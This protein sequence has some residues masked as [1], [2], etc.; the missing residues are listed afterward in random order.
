[1]F[2]VLIACLLAGAA[3][4]PD[5]LALAG[6]AAQAYEAGDYTSAVERYRALTALLPESPGALSGLGRSLACLGRTA[7]ALEWLGRAADTRAGIDVAAVEAAFG[8]AVDDPGVRALLSRL[9]GNLTPLVASTLAFRLAEKDL[10]P[11]SVA[12]DPADGAFYV[13]SL[14]KRKIVTV[15]DG[16]ARDFVPAK[17]HGLGAVLGMK[18]DASRRELWANSCHG[19]Y[20]PALEDPDPE[21]RGE[22]AVFRFA[23]PSG[24]LLAV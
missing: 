7:E 24:S 17:A 20:P 23:L 11:E 5:P 8:S 12:H 22:A 18:V 3:G 19:D 13:G 15:L 14:R 9:R 1:M 6:K 10:F 2:N 16:V 21:R 4:A